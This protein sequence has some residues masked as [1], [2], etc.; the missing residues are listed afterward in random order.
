MGDYGKHTHT[1]THTFF[2]H[3]STTDTI[4]LHVA[5]IVN[6]AAMNIEV[7]ISLQ[8]SDLREFCHGSVVNESDEE[9]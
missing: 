4:C 1:H 7:K 9:P 3:S 6:H 2:M 8:N 5:T